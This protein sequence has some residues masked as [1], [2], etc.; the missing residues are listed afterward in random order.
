MEFQSHQG[1]SLSSCTIHTV[2]TVVQHHS[3]DCNPLHLVFSELQSILNV[4][5]SCVFLLFRIDCVT[6]SWITSLLPIILKIALR[7]FLHVH[8]ALA[9][10]PEPIFS[11]DFPLIQYLWSTF[12]AWI[13]SYCVPRHSLHFTVSMSFPHCFLLWKCLLSCFLQL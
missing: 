11:S 8:K 1:L 4:A 9:S 7:L 6:I 2:P 5:V 10:W 13:Q 12:S 3:R